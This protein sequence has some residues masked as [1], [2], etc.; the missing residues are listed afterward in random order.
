VTVTPGPSLQWQLTRL[1]TATAVVALLLT[2]V[3][4][5]GYQYATA[6][7]DLQRELE[8]LADMVGATSSAA[9]QFEDAPKAEEI[10]ASA[11]SV[12][13]RL[14]GASLQTA[15]GTTLA[16]WRRDA[17]GGSTPALLAAHRP[18][19]LDG[20]T[21]GTIRLL[22]DPTDAIARWEDYVAIVTGL[23]F[24]S[25]LIALLLSAR[26]QRTVSGPILVLAERADQVSRARDYSLR[27]VRDREDEIGVLYDRFNEML[28]AVQQRDT[29]LQDAHDLLEARVE[30]RTEALTTEIEERRRTEEQLIVARNAADAA[31]RAKS[32]FL[33]NMSH[34]LR[35]PLNAVLGFSELLLHDAREAGHAQM[36]EDLERIQTAGRQLLRLV[37]DVLDLSRIEVGRMPLQAEPFAV[38][39]LAAEVLSTAEPLA[40]KNGN[41]LERVV[42]DDIGAMCGDLTRVA[43]V[44]LN[45]L[46][47]AAKFTHRGTIRFEV[48]RVAA[49]DAEW[50]RF[51]VRDTGIGMTADQL[52]RIFE[53]FTQAD[54]SI[55]RTYG[56]TGLGLA[57]SRRLCRMMGGEITATS[58]PGQGSV[59]TVVVPAV[60]GPEAL[61]TGRARAAA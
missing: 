2:C 37:S 3:V 10:L 38:A 31:N 35:T 41:A 18:I 60:L 5:I 6:R 7:R 39:A 40:A 43:Q 51:V 15:Q 32:A 17:T 54:E 58:T 4:L 23:L 8:A 12:D 20:E 34:E 30:E 22:A 48:A 49:D 29:A 56:G 14:V 19:R 47:N 11:V 45:V 21:I 46:G 13:R 61:Q 24:V 44:L 50:I 59:F 33:A 52:G 9:V 26:M 57:I 16:D 1:M 36:A 42:P 25:L 28:A 53:E 55:T 27:V